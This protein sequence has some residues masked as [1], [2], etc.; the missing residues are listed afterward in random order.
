MENDVFHLL[1]LL[2]KV[3]QIRKKS[4]IKIEKIQIKGKTTI[5]RKKNLS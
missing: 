5:E 3:I 4:K 2:K 1:L